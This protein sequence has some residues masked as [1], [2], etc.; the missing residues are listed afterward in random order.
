[1]CLLLSKVS[2]LLRAGVGYSQ[3]ATKGLEGGGGGGN[4][5]WPKMTTATLFNVL[6]LN[7]CINVI[8]SNWITELF[9]PFSWSRC[10]MSVY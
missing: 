4:G 1:M 3:R 2:R 6:P 7:D 9:F 8:F 5:R 10:E